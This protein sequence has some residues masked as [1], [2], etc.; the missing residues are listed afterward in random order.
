MRTRT[1]KYEKYIIPLSD[2]NPFERD[3]F[4]KSY[5]KKI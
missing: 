3:E 2:N 4:E 1:F 5:V